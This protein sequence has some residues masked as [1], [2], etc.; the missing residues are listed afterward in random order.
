RNCSTLSVETSRNLLVCFLWIIKNADQSLIQRWV[1]DI[2]PSQLSRLLELLTICTSCF[3]YR[4]KSS[5]KVSVQALQKSQQ[6]KARLEEALLGGLGA[7]GEMMKR[8]GANDRTLGQKENLRWRKDLTQWRQTNDRQDKSKAELDQEAIISGN[9]ATES[10]LIVLDLLEIIVQTVPLADYKDSAVGGVLRVLL[11][12][13]TC[14][15]STTY[16][17]H[18][19]STIRALIVK[20]L[21]NCSYFA[22]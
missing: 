8:V 22:Q 14:N 5:D 6:A 12:S 3:D 17:S 9:L 20:V 2:S 15:Q 16:L 21:T 1:L 4:G 10:N 7:R 19:F 18:C 13:L 11:H